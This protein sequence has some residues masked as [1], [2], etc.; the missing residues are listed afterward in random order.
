MLILEGIV[1]DSPS[2]LKPIKSYYIR[3]GS[4]GVHTDVE[5]NGWR[6]GRVVVDKLKAVSKLGLGSL[7]FVHEF[8]R[9]TILI[10]INQAKRI[11]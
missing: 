4:P 10:I 2:F 6:S 11:P 1:F 8:Q 3:K 9:Y 7:F 5:K